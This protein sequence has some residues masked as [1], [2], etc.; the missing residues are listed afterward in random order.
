MM[1]ATAPLRPPAPPAAPPPP[2]QQ[3]QAPPTSQEL[4]AKMRTYQPFAKQAYAAPSGTVQAPTGY[5]V[6]AK[7][8]NENRTLFASDTDPKKAVL[9]YRGTD[10]KNRND[11]G[12]D[13]LLAF[14][15]EGLSARFQNAKRAAKAAQN[16]YPDLTLTG[17][18]LGGS[19]ALYA[20]K[21]LKSP[22]SQT[23]AY[24]PHVSLAESFGKKL[25]SKVHDAFFKPKE[26][27][28]SNTYIYKT[29]LDPVSAFVSPHYDNSHVVMVKQRKLSPHDLGNFN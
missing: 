18:S 11:L 17:H 19:E 4:E 28:P 14:H 13:A 29:Q 25:F 24:S 9:S 26:A 21:S 12:T 23:V 2:G 8:S 5:H 15:L 16:A 22:P 20:S 7:Y 3:P 1:S 6:D 27:Q 10:V